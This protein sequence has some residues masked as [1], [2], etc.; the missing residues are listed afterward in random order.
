ML[1]KYGIV[2]AESRTVSS[3]HGHGAKAV[4]WSVILQLAF[5]SL[6]VVYGDI[7]TSPLC[8]YASTFTNDIRHVDD[9]LGVFSLIIYTLSLIPLIKYVFIVLQANDN[10]DEAADC[11]LELPRSRGSRGTA[12]ALRVK[13]KLENSQFAKPFLLITA[14]LGTC[15][16]IGDGVVT[17]C[18]SVISAVR[19]IR[20]ATSAMTEERI[21]WISVAILGCLFMIQQFGTDKIGYIFAPIICVWFALIGGIGIYNFFKFDPTV[22]KAINPIYIIEYFRRNKKEAWISL[23]GVVLAITGS[24]A[25][26]GDVGHFTVRSI[27][28]SMCTVTYPTLVL[29]YVGQAPPSFARTKIFV[30]IVHTSAK[31]KVQIY[32]PEVN[33]LLMLACMGV[34]LGFKDPKKI[35][36]AYALLVLIMIIIW[37]SSMFFIR[38]YVLTIGSVESVYSSSVLYKFNQGGYLP[39]AFAVFLITVMYIWNNVFRRKHFYELKHKVSPG[40]LKEI[41]ADTKVCR[42]PG[43]AIFY[44]ELV[45]GIP[46]IFER[47]IYGYRDSCNG[48]ADR[49]EGTLIEKL[50]EFVREGYFWSFQG[51]V[52][53]GDVTEVDEE[54]GH[55]NVKLVPQEKQKEALEREIEM[56]DEAS[57]AGVVHLIGESERILIDYG[58]NFL[59]S[60]S[61]QSDQLFDIPREKMLKVRMTY[62]L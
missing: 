26:F 47:Y 3:H 31:F 37:K 53:E 32:I 36:N 25:L 39:L 42:I 7:G 54:S 55:E 21:V 14:M 43:L 23:G 10:G 46:P 59:K 30:K 28:I 60:N 52:N 11:N 51:I 41:V 9:I 49:F 5:Q 50:K 56:V 48:A 40:R 12:M 1:C 20:E 17:P 16:L 29:A 62:D 24:E 4:K 44:S 2:D 18:V 61:R 34:T 22:I 6:G 33:Y 27:Q 19:G 45:Q 8:V 13:H 58:Y 15:I 57:R 38:T 35:G